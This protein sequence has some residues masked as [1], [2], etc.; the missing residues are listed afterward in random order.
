MGSGTLTCTPDKLALRSWMWLQEK[1][2]AR[3]GRISLAAPNIFMADHERCQKLVLD[4]STDRHLGMNV[5][6]DSRKNVIYLP[7]LVPT[8]GFQISRRAILAITP[9]GVVP[10]GPPTPRA[11]Y[12][13]SRRPQQRHWLAWMGD[14]DS[15]RVA[16]VGNLGAPLEI[17]E[18]GETK[19]EIPHARRRIRE[20]KSGIRSYLRL[21]HLKSFAFKA[22]NAVPPDV[23]PSTISSLRHNR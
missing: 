6:S 19:M 11:R 8:T 21:C 7:D 5:T 20:T 1:E 18:Q 17:N 14:L 9:G 4:R 15:V 10:R 22:I 12:T 16:V 3:K 13:P 23:E 2:L